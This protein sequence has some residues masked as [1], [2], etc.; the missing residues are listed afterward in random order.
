MLAFCLNDPLHSRQVVTVGE[1]SP[2]AEGAVGGRPK[3]H[4]KLAGGKG[5][6]RHQFARVSVSQ[7]AVADILTIPPAESVWIYH[8]K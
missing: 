3:N 6:S 4:E 1:S 2:Q 8:E 5:C 7:S